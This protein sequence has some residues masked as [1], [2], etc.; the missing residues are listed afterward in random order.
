MDSAKAR[1][2]QAHPRALIQVAKHAVHDVYDAIVELVTNSDDRYQIL[3]SDGVIEIELERRRTTGQSILRVRDFADG[4]DAATME[5]KLSYMGGRDSGLDTGQAVRGTHSRGAKDVAALGRVLFESVAADGRF[6]FCEITPYL[7]FIPHATEDTTPETRA[8]LGI[9]KGTGTLVTIELDRT[10]RVPNHDNLKDQTRRLVCLRGI[11]A[12]PRRTLVL[13]DVNQQRQDV[14]EAPR[15]DGSDQLKETLQVSGYPGVTAKLIIQRAKERFEKESPRFRLGGILIESKRA[16]H[17]ATLFDSGLESNPYALWFY[18]RLV[19]PAIDDLCVGFDDRIDAKLPPEDDNPTYPLDPSRRSG[20]TREHPFVKALFSDVLKRLRPLVEKEREREEHERA[21][22]ENHATRKRLDALQ[23]AA[24]EFMRDFGEDEEAARDPEGGNPESRF[25]ERGFALSPPF[26]QI[27]VGHSRQFW[28]TVRLETFPELEVGSTVQIEC[29]SHD[30]SADKQYCG[31]EPHP[32]REGVLRAVW[33]VKALAPTPA[34]GLRV[35]VGSINEESIIEVL[36]SEADRYKDVTA[37]RFA[38]KRYRMRTDQ[39][40]K[41]VRVLAPISLAPVPTAFSVDVDSRHFEVSGQ[42]L[43]QPRD[44]LGVAVC[45]F[46]VKGDGKEAAATLSATLRG[47]TAVAEIS[48]HLPLGADLKIAIE[49]V[50]LGNQR[51]RWLQNVLQIAARHPS[52]KRYL[53]DKEHGFQGQDSKHFRLLIAE[54]V[55]DAVCALVVRRNVQ[56][57]PEEYE[58]ADWD[59]YYAQYSKYMTQFLPTA[60]K[61]QCPEG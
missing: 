12:D 7:E 14:L 42:C 34:T 58:D 55:A 44:D 36:S 61:L 22:I 39:K 43:L 32:T 47:Q 37:L 57:N 20:L 9:L 5:R 52:L 26:T 28:L 23:K 35:R 15:I 46:G 8:R 48:S 6:H 1:P 41:A 24:L 50:D 27:V 51:Y 19:C 18:G 56:A 60:H 38:K 29:L 16:I 17:E 40:R 10:Q 21:R 11:L 30:I 4:M 33:N 53:G 45:E 3:Q 2:V 49:D 54:V 13:K 31:L 25:L 59:T